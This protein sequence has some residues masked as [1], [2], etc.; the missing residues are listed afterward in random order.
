MDLPDIV[1]LT[2]HMCTVCMGGIHVNDCNFIM[3]L[4]VFT[5]TSLCTIVHTL[6]FITREW[7]LL[8]KVR[9]QDVRLLNSLNVSLICDLMVEKKKLKYGV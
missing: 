3:I 6:M 8:N 1:S 4:V 5:S 9:G 2:M 7:V